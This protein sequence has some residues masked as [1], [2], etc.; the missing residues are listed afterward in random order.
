MADDRSSKLLIAFVIFLVLFNYP[1]LDIVDKA[2]LWFGFPAL[3]FYLFLVWGGLILVVA[4][5]M[6]QGKRKP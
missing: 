5:I 3:Y 4:Q 1:L 2:T 6:K